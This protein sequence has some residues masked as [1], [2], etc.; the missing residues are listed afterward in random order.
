MASLIFDDQMF[1]REVTFCKIYSLE[2][3][4][5]LEKI[6]LRNRISYF[7]DWQERSFFARLMGGEKQKGKDVFTVRIN[8]ADVERASELVKGLDVHQLRT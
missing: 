3:K 2:S 1:N 5:K 7:I 8:E 6:F 4:E